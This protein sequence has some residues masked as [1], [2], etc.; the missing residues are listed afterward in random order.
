MLINLAATVLVVDCGCY[1]PQRLAILSDIGALRR[2]WGQ[3]GPE[4]DASF[5][6][7]SHKRYLA[8]L[9]REYHH[10]RQI[11]S[12]ECQIVFIVDGHQR[13]LAKPKTWYGRYFGSK[14]W[15]FVHGQA[16]TPKIFWKDEIEGEEGRWRGMICQVEGEANQGIYNFF[17]KVSK[18]R[19]WDPYFAALLSHD[20]NLFFQIP[21][22]WCR[23]RL[24]RNFS[25]NPVSRLNSFIFLDKLQWER[26]T[27]LNT[28][29]R[30][31]NFLCL[32]GHNYIESI[33][34]HCEGL[35]LPLSAGG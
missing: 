32:L 17:I 8:L 3:V 23:F 24:L 5:L 31:L 1:Y 9:K 35:S 13:P 16:P 14:K 34:L 2:R 19:D 25:K 33:G 28:P 29:L 22:E 11:V 6:I 30:S 18:C 15:K 12:P 7:R 4:Y 27:N 20:Y 26:I 10:Y 21:A